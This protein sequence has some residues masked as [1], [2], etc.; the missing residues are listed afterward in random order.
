V[1][2]IFFGGSVV[3]KTLAEPVGTVDVAPTLAEFIAVDPPA[4][5]DGRSLAS[6]VTTR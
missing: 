4:Q 5:I 6:L 2:L 3:A 1:P